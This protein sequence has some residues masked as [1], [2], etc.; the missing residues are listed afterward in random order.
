M[1]K[2]LDEFYELVGTDTIR[3][4]PKAIRSL[5]LAMTIG[6][7]RRMRNE[8]GT[9]DLAKKEIDIVIFAKKAM[10]AADPAEDIPYLSK[11]FILKKFL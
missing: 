4:I 10:R 3:S 8:P 6:Q 1:T 9:T 11:R 5:Y 7:L 2:D